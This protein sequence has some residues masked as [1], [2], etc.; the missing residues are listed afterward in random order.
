MLQAKGINYKPGTAPQ[1]S[2]MLTN[3]VKL[4]ELMISKDAL[5]HT[6]VIARALQK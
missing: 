2:S 4:L 1:L 3:K 5:V 6:H